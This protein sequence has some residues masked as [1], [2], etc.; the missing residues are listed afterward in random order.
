MKSINWPS[1]YLPRTTDNF[2]SNEAISNEITLEDT[3]INLVD[4]SNWET[5]YDNA[6]N[7]ELADKS[8]SYLHFA[9]IFHFDT[10]GF[11]I[12]AQVMELVEPVDGKTARI[13]WHGW[14]NGDS[15]TQFDVI[16]AFL[17]EKLN[18][19]LIRLLTQESQIGRPAADLAKQNSNPM[20]NGHQAWID[21]LV[22][23]AKK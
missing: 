23:A 1:E 8:S 2:V 16:H 15:E 10:F 4:T 14:Q 17:I 5:Y 3:W 13:T 21:G 11:P 18:D 20:L 19:G 12:D 9:E 6:T 22:K 7:I